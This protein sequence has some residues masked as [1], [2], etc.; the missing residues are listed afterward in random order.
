MKERYTRNIPALSEEQQKALADKKALVIGCGGLG[1]YVVEELARLGVGH[2]TVTD[3]DVF[4][5]SNLN[6]Q[7]FSNVNNIGMSKTEEAAKRINDVNQDIELVAVTSFLPVS[8]IAELVEEAD[9]V[10]DALDNVADRL[11]LEELCEA[12]GV[13]LVHGAVQ[14]WNLQVGLSLPGSKL[15]HNLYKGVTPGE[16]NDSPEAKTVLCPTV[17]C[18]ASLQA[19]EALKVLIGQESEIANKIFIMDLR[20]LENYTI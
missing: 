1:G 11:T 8:E 20:T 6:R 13:A 18:C 7:L 12:A 19:A 16:S 17:A 15:L 14:G 3:G 2:I 5:E 9:V 4:S 10:V